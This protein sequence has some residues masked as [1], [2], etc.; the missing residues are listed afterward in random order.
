MEAGRL[1]TASKGSMVPAYKVDVM[2]WG[3]IVRMVILEIDLC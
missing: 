2:K 1:T 3:R